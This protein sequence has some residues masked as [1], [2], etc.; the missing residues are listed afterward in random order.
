MR[1]VV[2]HPRIA[3]H[4]GKEGRARVEKEYSWE[5]FFMKFDAMAR[6][7]AQSGTEQRKK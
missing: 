3:E 7:V 2:E 5:S 4:M 1:F 6:K